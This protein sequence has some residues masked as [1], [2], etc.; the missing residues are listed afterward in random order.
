MGSP[1]RDSRSVDSF[2]GQNVDR[3]LW[4]IGGWS[5][6]KSHFITLIN[7][8]IGPTHV[9]FDCAELYM[10]CGLMKFREQLVGLRVWAEKEATEGGAEKKPTGSIQKDLFFGPYIAPPTIR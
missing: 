3:E 4:T 9:F 7:N 10:D 1:V 6:G 8:A 5:V 2:S